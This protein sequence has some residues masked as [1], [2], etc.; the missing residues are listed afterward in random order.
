MNNRQGHH[1]G[2]PTDCQN[3][4]APHPA[5]SDLYRPDCKQDGQHRCHGRASGDIAHRTV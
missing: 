3:E 5:R 4:H 2:R 1:K